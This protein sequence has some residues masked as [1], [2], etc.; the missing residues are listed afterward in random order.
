ME[1]LIRNMLNNSI[2]T[3]KR[4]GEQLTDKIKTAAE[5]IIDCYRKGGKVILFGNG[6]SAA[7]SQHI[8]TELIHQFELK[9]RKAL[10]AI[11]LSTNTSTLSA[12]GNDWGFE[13]V[14]ERQVEGLA[15]AGDVVIGFTTSGNSV[16]VIKGIEMA[17]HKKAF[18][19]A[20]TGADGGKIKEI[21]DLSLVV[22]N[23]NTARIQESHI[24]IWHILCSLI[25]K[26]LFENNNA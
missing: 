19:I 13:R 11:A 8:A 1:D 18:T 16:N 25:E 10:A 20:L 15:N 21:A 3:K 9:G 2:E 22:P 14:F 26:E 4:V 17:K 23:E 12:I 5:K 7:D 24:T 6:G